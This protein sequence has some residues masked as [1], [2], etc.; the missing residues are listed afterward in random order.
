M[1]GIGLFIYTF[2]IIHLRC[3]DTAR[4]LYRCG[5]RNAQGLKT[6]NS[7][8]SLYI[9]EYPAGTIPRYAGTRY[10]IGNRIKRNVYQIVNREAGKAKIP[11]FRS[12]ERLTVKAYHPPINR[13]EA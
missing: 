4:Y 13:T 1:N 9:V 3:A 6:I 11:Y 12:N 2:S 8:A 10:H 7:D 5:D